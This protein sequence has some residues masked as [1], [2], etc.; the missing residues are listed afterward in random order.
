MVIR[1]SCGET[2]QVALPNRS[3]L[4]VMRHWHIP[5]FNCGLPGK[6]IVLTAGRSTTAFEPAANSGAALMYGENRGGAFVTPYA[7][8]IT[9][10]LLAN[11]HLTHD[12][13]TRGFDRLS[14]SGSRS[15]LALRSR[16]PVCVGSARAPAAI[17]SDADPVAAEKSLVMGIE[18]EGRPYHAGS[19]SGSLSWRISSPVSSS[20]ADRAQ[21]R[22]SEYGQL[23]LLGAA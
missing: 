1:W 10:V 18:P 8:T 7:W 11:H 13:G 23:S 4:M 9:T 6:Y 14:G 15:A 16:A 20:P 3:G 21:V 22:H 5:R 19:M 12:R 17:G 2:A